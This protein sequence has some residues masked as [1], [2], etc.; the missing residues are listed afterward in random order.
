M[1]NLHCEEKQKINARRMSLATYCESQHCFNCCDRRLLALVSN[2]PDVEYE[3]AAIADPVDKETMPI[4]DAINKVYL[5]PLRDKN[6]E[7]AAKY[8]A[9]TLLDNG[10]DEIC[11]STSS[12]IESK[13]VKD[14]CFMDCVI[15]DIARRC[16]Y[17]TTLDVLTFVD[18]CRAS[19][20]LGPFALIGCNTADVKDKDFQ[21]F[22]ITVEKSSSSRCRVGTAFLLFGYN[23][24]GEI[25]KHGFTQI[26]NQRKE[27]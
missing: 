5:E 14:V 1:A 13:F 8:L 27:K 19:K 26:L 17:K 11:V 21:M 3:N 18:Q 12:T 20:L 2:L 9:Q 25:D 22:F 7:L 6:E 16:D 10:C 23:E 15:S 24:R 4:I